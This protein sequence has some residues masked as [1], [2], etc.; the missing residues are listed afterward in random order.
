MASPAKKNM[1]PA[2]QIIIP[3]PPRLEEMFKTA[4]RR[5]A[6]IGAGAETSQE[7]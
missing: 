1:P 7:L 5:H 6:E 2:P 4:G 3:A